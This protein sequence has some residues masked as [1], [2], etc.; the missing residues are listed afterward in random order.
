M[1]LGS[2]RQN[3]SNSHYIVRI[4]EMKIFHQVDVPYVQKV[5]IKRLLGQVAEMRLT[6]I[7]LF[8]L[9]RWKFFIKI[10]VHYD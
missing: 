10:D 6:A 8:E 5:G 2:G 4:G 1:S 7:S 9:A 3:E